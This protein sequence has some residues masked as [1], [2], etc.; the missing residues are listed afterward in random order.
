MNIYR[1]KNNIGSKFISFTLA[2][3]LLAPSFIPFSVA[4]QT[5]LLNESGSQKLAVEEVIDVPKVL[6]GETLTED[7][8]QVNWEQKVSLGGKEVKLSSEEVLTALD[9]DSEIA[10]YIRL[11]RGD[12]EAIDS[13]KSSSLEAK[14]DKKKHVTEALEY[15]IAKVLI[16]KGNLPE[17]YFKL[18]LQD[19]IVPEENLIDTTKVQVRQ[20]DVSRGEGFNTS[21]KTEVLNKSA[22][23]HPEPITEQPAVEISETGPVSFLKS[24][25]GSVSNIASRFFKSITGLFDVSIAW[26]QTVLSPRNEIYSP[27]FDSS[28]VRW[29]FGVPDNTTYTLDVSDSGTIKYSDQDGYISFT[30]L[31]V[32]W[33][34]QQLRSVEQKDFTQPKLGEYEYADI[35][36]SGVSLSVRGEGRNIRKNVVI[37]SLGA[38]GP[39]PKDVQYLEIAFSVDTDYD[40][41][42]GKHA[43]KLPL[44]KYSIMLTPEVYDSQVI[45]PATL[46]ADNGDIEQDP[47]RKQT[48]IEWEFRKSGDGYIFV[49]YVPVSWLKDAQYPVYTDVDISYGSQYEFDTGTLEGVRTLKLD[50]DKFAVCWTDGADSYAEG[51]CIVGS[52]S[53]TT[54]SYGSSSQFASDITSYS[55]FQ[56]SA[57]KAATDKIAVVYADDTSTDEGYIR[58]ATVTGTTIG[59]WGTAQQLAGTNDLESFDCVGIDTDKV[60]VIYNNEGTSDEAN[61]IVCTASGTTASCGSEDDWSST[62]YFPTYTSVAKI[63]TDKFIGCTPGWDTGTTVCVIGSVSGTTITHGTVLTVDSTAT[64]VP[65]VSVVGLD[66]DK[67]VVGIGDGFGTSDAW[68]Y[69]ATISGTTITKGSS[70]AL[71]SSANVNLVLAEHDTTH[72]AALWSEGLATLE[73]ISNYGSVNFGT[74]TIT[75]G[76]SETFD[77]SGVSSSDYGLDVTYLGDNK[78]VACYSDDNDS[79]DG[80][81]L[82]GELPS[83]AGNSAPSAP[84]SL[85]SEGQTNPTNI[86]D[87]SPE[88]SAIYEDTD[89]GDIADYYQIQVDNNSDFSSTYW[90]STKTSLASSTPEG[91]RI[92]DI[93]YAGSALASS[94][95]YY[96]RIKFWDDEDAEGVWS[97]GTNTFSLAAAVNNAP[98]SPTSLETEGQT[99]PTDITDSTPEFSAIYNDSDSGDIATDYQI[100]VDDNSDFSSTYWDGTKTSLASST[101]EGTR[102]ADISYGGS[103]L[104]SSTTYYWRIKFWDDDDAE[105]LWSTGTNTFS[106]AAGSSSGGGAVATTTAAVIDFL[107]NDQNQDGSWGSG[108]NK[109][110]TTVA[111]VDALNFVGET[112]TEYDSGI[113]WLDSY[114]TNN[115]DFLAQQLEVFVQSG[116]ATSTAEILAYALDEGTGGFVFDRGYESDPLTTA[117]ALQALTESEYED[118]G[119]NPDLTTALAMYYLIQTQ[120]FDGGWSV[121]D[122]GV[123]SIPVT[124]EV[125]G[126]L[127]PYKHQSLSGFETEDVEIDDTLDPAVSSLTGT[128]M[129]NG[130]WNNNLLNTALAFYTIKAAGTNPIYAPD[131]LSYLQSQQGGDGSFSNGNPYVTAKVLKALYVS[132]AALGV[133]VTDDIVPLTSLQTSST[134]SIRIDITNSGDLTVDSGVLHVLADDYLIGSFDFATYGIVIEPS[135]TEEITVDIPNTVGYVGDV[136][137]EVFVEGADDIVYPDSRYSETLSFAEADG[138]MPG[139][140]IYFIAHKYVIGNDP[141]IN[142]R[143]GQKDDSNRLNY[144]FMWRDPSATTTWSYIPISNE[145]NGSFVY[146]S[147]DEDTLYEVTVGA[148]SLDEENFVYYTT[149]VEVKT[150][151]DEE[152]YVGGSASGTLTSVLGPVP[153]M[154]ILGYNTTDEDGSFS[155]SGVPWG[156]NWLVVDSTNIQNGFHY[157]PYITTFVTADTSVTDHIA[158]TNPVIDTSAP[159]TTYFAIANESDFI[160][161]NKAEKTIHLGVDD[162]VGISGTGVVESATFYYYDP[163]DTE[164]HLIGTMQGPL[165]TTVAY[166]WYIPGMLLGENYKIKVIVRD[167]SGKESDPVEWGPFEITE[168]NAAPEFTFVAPSPTSST[169]AD[170]SYTIKWT[171]YDE[172]DNATITLF[173]DPDSDPDNGNSTTIDTVYEDDFLDQYEWTTSGVSEGAY[174]IRAIVSDGYNGTVVVTSAQ[175][176]TVNHSA[177]I[178]PTDLLTEGQTNPIDIDDSTPELS[179]IF[180]DPNA[181]ST[182]EYYRIQV[183]ATST[184]STIY[185]DSGKTQL[186]SPTPAGTRIADISYAGSALASSTT[187]YWR[188][189]FWDESDNEGLWSTTTPSFSLA[190]AVNHAPTAPSSLETEGQTNP[191]GVADPTPEFSAIYN[192]PDGSDSANK[193]RIQV[194]TT[195]DFTYIQWDSGTTTMATTTVGNRSPEISYAGSSLASSTPYYW[196]V[197]FVDVGDVGG[198]WSTTTSSFSLSE[199]QNNAPTAPSALL[200]EGQTNP[201][202]IDDPTPEFSAIH[203]DLDGGDSSTRYTLQVA[204]SSAFTYVY[205]DSGTT[206]MATTTVGNRSPDIAYG[207]S[208]LASSTTYYWRIRFSDD[209]GA[210]GAWSTTTSSFLLAEGGGGISYFYDSFTESGDSTLLSQHEP[211]TGSGWTVLIQTGTPC[212]LGVDAT[213]DRLGDGECGLSDGALYRTDDLPSS[214]D[215]EVSVVSVEPDGSDDYNFIACRI[216]DANNMYAFKWNE[217]DGQLYKR[218][219]GTWSTL[220][221]ATSGVAADSVVLLSCDGSTITAKDDSSTLVSV[222]DTSITSAGYGGVGMGAIVNGSD[223]VSNQEMDDFTLETL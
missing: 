28:N 13:S 64:Q 30:P 116:G 149:P 113:D 65:Y 43:G 74:R 23:E 163:N 132:T 48:D 36:G 61:S 150:S 3:G 209:S 82:I 146:G 90:D 131:T 159:T 157:E 6:I 178:A 100:Q 198:A 222:T 173:Y 60:A 175:M 191:T 161:A 49:K 63:D 33:D 68:A 95:T 51:K 204:T 215:V 213:Y 162:D 17:D 32:S 207:G 208:S 152:E 201:I 121:F 154:P 223:D 117:H 119:A 42:L 93:S 4:A 91:T 9:I 85:L 89:N 92:A 83:G 67:A 177:P 76:T 166:S 216:Q 137:F 181:T 171:D 122:G 196:R 130:T 127:L 123:S 45:S 52:I 192:D 14:A 96:W 188:I 183:S 220:G 20:L 141:A 87:S 2:V 203:N 111:V 182:A 16:Q 128:Q 202:D 219:S 38:I 22:V 102:I 199:T 164:W 27:S 69:A 172:E 70:E 97:A 1:F 57:C 170:N 62:D 158:L 21:S 174:Y 35:F 151:S 210:T 98:T 200:A 29:G 185:W 106:L 88:F 73:G 129:S 107:I 94:T 133:L 40:I 160:M 143:W 167:Y 15:S 218:V 194:S 103:A 139:L 147:F 114:I 53:G 189:K 105:G 142:V 86:S 153:N 47:R 148:M 193:Y 197:A 31:Y 78:I 187:Y 18:K 180:V 211:D 56:M 115:N 169:Q 155:I 77:S 44:G 19:L 125:I 104:A 34:E 54:I 217:D 176:V 156:S 81:C 46:R 118:P 138:D 37:D 55:G 59:S 79:S 72:F 190:A 26:A 39:I 145:L 120:R 110:I 109:F 206:T 99:N 10:K 186:A 134:T 71:T 66:T 184:L 58:F 50:D 112:G 75:A 135:E 126:A 101:T 140:P 80:K 25:W 136:V 124:T 195:T 8:S 84:T 168:G 11:Y 214:A 12:V 5:P 144:M 41:P 179:A 205:W 7:L 212:E 24:I 165:S 221:S 108:S